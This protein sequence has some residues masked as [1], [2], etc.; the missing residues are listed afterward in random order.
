M[1]THT[2]EKPY[3]CEV[4]GRMFSQKSAATKHMKKH[5]E[6]RPH[7][8]MMCCACVS[9]GLWD[10]T[11]YLKVGM[12]WT[13][14][15]TS[16]ASTCPQGN[17]STSCCGYVKT[18]TLRFLIKEA[19]LQL[20]LNMS[21]Y[22]MI[23]NIDFSSHVGMYLEKAINVHLLLICWSDQLD[24][25]SSPFWRLRIYFWQNKIWQNKRI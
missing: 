25:P 13:N 8:W 17:L 9:N 4:C 21:T 18:S 3:K 1:R 22:E 11:D 23:L 5:S 10:I 20:C 16:N 19:H 6:N 12:S 24:F 15:S 14:Q 7:Q 2:G